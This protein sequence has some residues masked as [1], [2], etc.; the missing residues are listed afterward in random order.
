MFQTYNILL[1]LGNDNR[2]IIAKP[3]VTA[4]EL[5]LLRFMHGDDSI[6]EISKVGEASQSNVSE[7]QRLER[8]YKQEKVMALFGHY[9]ELPTDL[10]Q[11]TFRDGVFVEPKKKS[12]RPK[13]KVE[14][15]PV[16]ETNGEGNPT[17]DAN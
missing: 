9:G 2:S 14:T 15:E 8:R 5:L 13:K 11:A 1:A 16:E 17:G 12:G 7:R 6:Q 10:S 4:P 3:N